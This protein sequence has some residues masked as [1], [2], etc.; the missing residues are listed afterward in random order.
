MFNFSIPKNEKDAISDAKAHEK[1]NQ[2]QEANYD[3][4]HL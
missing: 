2:D 1:I 4:S 3:S